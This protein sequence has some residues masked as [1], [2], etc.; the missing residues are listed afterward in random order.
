MIKKTLIPFVA[1]AI[2]AVI[3][4]VVIGKIFESVYGG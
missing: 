3:V 2:P 1:A 4:L